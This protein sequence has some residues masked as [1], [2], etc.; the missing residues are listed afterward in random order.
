[1]NETDLFSHDESNLSEL[2]SVEK[3][4]GRREGVSRRSEVDVAE[5]RKSLDVSIL[6]G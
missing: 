4:C 5:E 1:M 2:S 6:V 3:S